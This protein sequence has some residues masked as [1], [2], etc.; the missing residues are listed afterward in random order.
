MSLAAD[1]ASLLFVS[2]S[3]SLGY[4]VKASY[5]SPHEPEKRNQLHFLPAIFPVLM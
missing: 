2:D 4:I 1:W 3:I 5:L